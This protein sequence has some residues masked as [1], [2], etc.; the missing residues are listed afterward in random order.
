MTK[1]AKDM[2]EYLQNNH[3]VSGD[4]IAIFTAK[5]TQYFAK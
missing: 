3:G 2:I 5:F 1:N 4:E